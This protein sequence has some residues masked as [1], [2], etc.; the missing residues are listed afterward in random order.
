MWCDVLDVPLMVSGLKVPHRWTTSPCPLTHT[1]PHFH[2][3][4]KKRGSN[5]KERKNERI[6]LLWNPV[7]IKAV[8]S[9]CCR[10]NEN[11]FSSFVASSIYGLIY[12][13][14][15]FKSHIDSL[16][17][18]RC[19]DPSLC[20]LFFSDVFH[21][22]QSTLEHFANNSFIYLLLFFFSF[23]LTSDYN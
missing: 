1:L 3:K 16:L 15:V 7:R 10:E 18:W 11:L 17:C 13:V 4:K 9:P 19:L 2:L 22:Q 21:I 8:K 5:I 12:F 20:L 6:L 23:L 14:C